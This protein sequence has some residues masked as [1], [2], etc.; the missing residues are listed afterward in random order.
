MNAETRAIL[1]SSALT[2]ARHIRE[3]RFTSRQ[4]VDAH[5]SRIAALHPTLNAVVAERF[6]DA[7]A[8]A[9]AADRLLEVGATP[10]PLHGVPCT[11]KSAFS[12]TGM[13]NDAGLVARRHLRATDDAPT[14]AR[15]RAAGAIPLAVS[16]TSELCMWMESDNRLY[17]RTSSAMDPRRTSGGSSGGEG[18]LVG[19][20][21]SPFGLG[22][23]VG[24]SIRMPAMFNGVFGHKV[25]PGWIPNDGQFPPA[26]SERVAGMLASGP[27]TRRAE[28]LWPLITILSDE[29]AVSGDPARVDLGALR[30]LDVR[31]DGREVVH[32]SLLAAQARLSDLLRAR[33]ARVEPRGFDRF[34]RSLTYWM[35]AIGDPDRPSAFRT[36]L[37]GGSRRSIARQLLNR[38]WGDGAH[39]LPA[40]VLAL[41]EDAPIPDRLRTS[42]L[43][44]LERFRDEL[45]CALGDDG[46][47]LYPSHRRPAPRHHLSVLRPFGWTYT[48]IFNALGFPVTQVPLGL[49]RRGRPVGVQ[50][51]AAP[52]G[53][54]RTVA[55]AL[56]AERAFGGWY[57][58]DVPEIPARRG[59]HSPEL[60]A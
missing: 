22:S 2:L 25:T 7:R 19:S 21:G 16:N 34:Q 24:G 33:G 27:L 36:L 13:P 29:G 26:S 38:L 40:V 55:V 41:I 4:V 20:G 43:D 15:L 10:G 53:D 46:V 59:P 28:D 56:A 42:V 37:G 47:L 14:V 54:A 48:A 17:G 8:E 60:H 57:L 23:D 35:T 45:L 52:G 31:G 6:A 51:V 18:A 50:V 5:I 39:T 11:V 1:S 12:L 58:P 49:D 32:P 3:R 30:V 44:D 9:D